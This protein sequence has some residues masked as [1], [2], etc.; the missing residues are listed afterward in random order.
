MYSLLVYLVL[1]DSGQS[2]RQVSELFI[3][4]I[5]QHGL[6]QKLARAI[7]SE[8]SKSVKILSNVY[9]LLQLIL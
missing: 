1:L 9:F 3:I 7:K 8:Q 6:S 5:I 2:F 4:I